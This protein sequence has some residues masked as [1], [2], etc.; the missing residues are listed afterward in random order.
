M[1]SSRSLPVGGVG[2]SVTDPFLTRLYR[3]NYGMSYK[4]IYELVAISGLPP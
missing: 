1:S 3:L 2:A 4:E